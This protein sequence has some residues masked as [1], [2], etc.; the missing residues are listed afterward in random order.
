M[1]RLDEPLAN[2]IHD[3]RRD[4]S[5][6]ELY[7]DKD[8]AERLKLNPTQSQQSLT[9]HNIMTVSKYGQEIL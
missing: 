1:L 3:A 4:M 8:P 9:D 2:L 5:L 7:E 6:D